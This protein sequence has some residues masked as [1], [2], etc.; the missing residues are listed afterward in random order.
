VP[1]VTTELMKEALEQARRAR[2]HILDKM[3][4]R[5]GHAARDAFRRTRHAFYTLKIPTDKIAEVI[6]PGG[7]VIKGIIEQT[8]GQDRCPGSSAPRGFGRI[9]SPE[10][11]HVR[12]VLDIDLDAGL[13]DD[14]LDDLA[15]RS[16][17][18]AD[19]IG[20][21]L[22]CVNA[23]RVRRKRLARRGQHG[24]ILSRMCNRARRACS[25][26]SFISSVV[27]FGT[28][29]SIWSAVMPSRVPA[30]FEVHIGR[31]GPR[32]PRCR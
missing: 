12:V 14:A 15:A 27:T 19:L 13:L 31:N 6:G 18:L 21:N 5:A 32:R 3:V 24:T 2:L 4:G 16:N 1:N 10:D 26:A 23:W 9:A 11:V 30:T 8:G 17:H 7:K 25:S 29:M 20:R 28:L 22:Q